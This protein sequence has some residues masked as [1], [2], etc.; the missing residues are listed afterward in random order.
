MARTR[1]DIEGFLD[2]HGHPYDV[3]D[4]DT[5]LV[6]IAPEQP[7]AV[8]RVEPPVAVLQV[9]VGTAHFDDPARSAAFYRRLLELN[10]RDLVHA[11][12]GL[13]GERVTLSAALELDNLDQNELEAALADLG[14]A[15]VEHVP[16]LRQMAPAQS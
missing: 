4:E 16:G 5:L 6:Q 14:L 8:L 3:L 2:N 12:Y 11:S 9:H 10:A 15:L 7:P 1:Q 13:D